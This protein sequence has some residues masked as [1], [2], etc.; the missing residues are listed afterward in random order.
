MKRKVEEMYDRVAAGQRIQEKRET[1][2]LSQEVLAEK[3]DRAPKY[4]S[5]IERG[6]C[7]LSLETLV[8]LSQALDMNI[9]YIIKGDLSPE[10]KDDLLRA[11]ETLVEMVSRRGKC[12]RDQ[13]LKLL[14][15][16]FTGIDAI[17]NSLK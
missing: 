5:D 2:G 13:A 8:A 1:L 6:K 4:L 15:V 10:E 11:Q 12:E 3:I 17:K 14:Q 16:Y 9:D 7:G